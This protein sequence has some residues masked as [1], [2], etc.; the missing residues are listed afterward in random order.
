[1]FAV[2]RS[3]SVS[4]DEAGL[5][6]TKSEPLLVE[7]GGGA[8]LVIEVS[9]PVAYLATAWLRPKRSVRVRLL[10]DAQT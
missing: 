3:L 5:D 1:L 8:P 10:A 7:V 4:I 2:F 9:V 6:W